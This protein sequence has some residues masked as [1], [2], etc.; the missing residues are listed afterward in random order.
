MPWRPDEVVEFWFGTEPVVAP[1]RAK[2]WFV[3]DPLFDAEVR[4]RFGPLIDDAAS[5]SIDGWLVEPRSALALVLALDQFPRNVYR[6]QPQAFAHDEKALASTRL[7][8]ERGHDL[9]LT[10]YQRLFVHLPF[11]HCEDPAVQAEAV[12][13]AEQLLDEVKLRAAP[14]EVIEMMKVALEFARKH[15]E[16]IARFG[17]FPHRNPILGRTSTGEELEYLTSPDAGF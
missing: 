8:I 10:P 7:L 4:D 16:V 3:K 9:S 2:R 15:A 14:I 12:S 6:G 11:S 5:G 17:R 1:E 13:R